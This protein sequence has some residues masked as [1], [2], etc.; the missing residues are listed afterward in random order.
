MSANEQKK[1][2]ITVTPYGDRMECGLLPVTELGKL[3]THPLCAGQDPNRV[4]HYMNIIRDGNRDGIILP[5]R[6]LVINAETG[7]VLDGTCRFMAITHA[8]KREVISQD[9]YVRAVLEHHHTTQEENDRVAEL[10]FGSGR[11]AT[12]ALAE[13]Y[14]RIERRKGT[15]GPYSRLQD[16][17]MSHSMCLCPQHNAGDQPEPDYICAAAMIKQGVKY[18]NLL[19]ALRRGLL[20]IT[21]EELASAEATHQALCTLCRR[22]DYPIQSMSNVMMALAW[23]NIKFNKPDIQ[24]MPQS[25]LLKH[26]PRKSHLAGSTVNTWY[27]AFTLMSAESEGL[28][29]KQG[30][31]TGRPE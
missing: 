30:M 19:S 17:A 8:L 10:A 16:F 27:S 5:S 3:S 6:E 2:T 11:A 22:M 14:A 25:I 12:N 20:E 4:N 24:N 31:E 15:D 9:S 13:A 18:S 21:Q 26:A 29:A 1:E 7:T 23:S 28:M